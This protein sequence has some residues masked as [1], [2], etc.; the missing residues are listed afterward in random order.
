VDWFLALLDTILGPVLDALPVA[1]LP[2]T[3]AAEA[4]NQVGVWLHTID[5]YMP[6]EAPIL[7]LVS[8]M[9]GALPAL[10]AYRI[11]LFIWKRIRG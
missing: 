1:E 4:V 2:G 3:W 7:F 6:I 11:A 10:L 9:A 5:Y 8:A